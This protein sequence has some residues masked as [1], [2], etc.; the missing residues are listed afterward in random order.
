MTNEKRGG[1]WTFDVGQKK[2]K[3][4]E[5]AEDCDDEEFQP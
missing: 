2:E 5:E 1:L 3:I 4:E